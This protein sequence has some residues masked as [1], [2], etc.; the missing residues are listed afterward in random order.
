MLETEDPVAGFGEPRSW[1]ARAALV[2][3]SAVLLPAV[4]VAFVIVQNPAYSKLDEPAHA[5]YLRRIEQGEVPRVGD[6]MLE[7]S[8]ADVQCRTV[9]GRVNAPCGLPSYEP[10]ILGANGYQYEA[11]QPPLYYVV[12]AGLRQLARIG[13]A[14]DFVTTARLTGVAWLSAGLLAFWAA[15]RRLGCGWW[16]TAIVTSLLTLGPGVL[17]QSATI[18][19]DAA[20]ILTGAAALLMFAVV[21]ERDGWPQVASWCAAAGLLVL[22]KPT[23]VV[24]VAAA[25]GALVLDALVERRLDVRR[26]VA[27]GLPTAVGLV[28]YLAWGVVRT[29]RSTVDYDVVLDALLSFKQVDRFPLDDIASSVTRLFG[30]YTGGGTPVSPPFATGP[31]MLVVYLLVGAGAAALWL[32]RGGAAAH[33]A[34]VVGLLAMV[35]GGPAFTLLFYLDYSVEGGPS[36]RYGLSL[37]PLLAA[38]A[39]HTYRTRRAMAVMVVLGVLV[40]IPVVVA[41]GWPTTRGGV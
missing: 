3:I 40:L 25:S 4:L 30:A 18:N 34:G 12:T 38:A 19:N 37:L 20:G 29:R 39:A 6:K 11:Q 9:Q 17:Y 22:V 2:V 26:A 32:R 35:V 27:F 13:P 21:R 36:A 31:A 28:T 15:C 10:E 8:V 24:S 1:W 5:D 33:R 41:T 14:D 16:P 7:E 23:G